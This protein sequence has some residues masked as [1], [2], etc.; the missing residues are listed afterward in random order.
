MF[1]TESS[2]FPRTGL[3]RR[4]TQRC[5]KSTIDIVLIVLLLMCAL[6]PQSAIASTSQS[7]ASTESIDGVP[8]SYQVE[9]Q[10]SPSLVFVHGWS[11]DRSYWAEQ[12]SYFRKLYRVIAIDL[13]GHGDSGK[14]AAAAG[15]CAQLYDSGS[16][17]R[18]IRDAEWCI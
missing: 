16:E 14:C 9:G 18:K 7:I 11:C 4:W 15:R 1:V 2:F 6:W 10:G 8:I 5:A 12:L 17:V 3:A 13:A